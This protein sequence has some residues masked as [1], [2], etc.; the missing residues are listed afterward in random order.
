MNAPHQNAVRES[1]RQRYTRP[2]N[3]ADDRVKSGDDAD[4]FTL[5]ESQLAQTIRIHALA[6]TGDAERGLAAGAAERLRVG[7]FRLGKFELHGIQIEEIETQSQLECS[8]GK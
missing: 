1:P 8:E 2:A 4:K 5:D 7:A 6:I 3:G